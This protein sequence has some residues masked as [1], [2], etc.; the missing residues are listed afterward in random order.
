LQKRETHDRVRRVYAVDDYRISPGV[1]ADVPV[2]ITWPNLR[3]ELG[4]WLT[5]PKPVAEGI[6]TARTLLSGRA[7]H[8]VVRVINLS[9]EPY[10]FHKDD[11]LGEA[12]LATVCTNDESPGS[13]TASMTSPRPA[14][15][16]GRRTASVTVSPGRSPN[17]NVKNTGLRD[18]HIKDPQNAG[19]SQNT[20]LDGSASEP[21]RIW[22]V[23]IGEPEQGNTNQLDDDNCAHVQ[24]LIDGLPRTLTDDQRQEAAEFI[25][26]NAAIF[27]KSEYDLGRTNL[28]EH[29]IDTGDSRPVRQ[30]LRRHPVAYL[31]LIDE[32]VDEMLRNNIIEPKLGSEWISDVV[33]VKK[34]DGSLR[35]CIDYRGLNAVTHKANYP[36][37]RIDSCLDSLGGNTLFS[38]LDMRSSYWQVKVKDEDV[39]KTCFVTRKGIYGFKVLPFGLCNAPST[40]QRLVDLALSGLTWKVCLAYLDDLIVFSRTF[41]EH[42][43]RLQLVFD[44]LEEADL[45]LKP[46]KCS[47]LQERVKFLGSVVTANG[48][49]PDPDKVQAVANWPRPQN[50][51]EVRSF[52]ALASYYRRHIHSFAEIARPLHELTKKNARFEWGLRQEDA[53]LSLKHGLTN[54]PVLAMPMDGGGFVLDTD[55]NQFS[56]R[57]VLQQVQKGVVKVIGYAS[58]AFS[59]AEL[60]YCTT[61]RELA[62]IIYGLKYYRHFLLGFPFVLR[63]D[64]AALTHL[65]RTP[66]PVAQSARYLDILAEYQFTVQYRPGLSHKN[67]DAL[68]RRPCGRG[69]DQPLCK[70]CG[71]I[72]LPSEGEA[73]PP[74]S[75][76][77][78]EDNIFVKDCMDH[79]DTIDEHSA[80]GPR[81]ASPAPSSV[82]GPQ[83][84][85]PIYSDGTRVATTEKLPDGTQLATSDGPAEPQLATSANTLG[86]RV[87]IPNFSTDPDEMPAIETGIAFVTDVVLRDQQGRDTVICVVRRWIETP[88]TVPDDNELHT[89]DPAIQHL[90]AQRQTLEVKDGILYR[91]YMRPDGVLRYLQVVVPRSLRAYFLDAVHTG[92]ING[93]MGVEK[94]QLKLQEIAYWQGWSYDVQMYVRRCHVCGSYRH[95][96]RRK[97]GQL[98]RALAND[99]MQKVHVDLVG[100]FPLSKKG[101]RYLLTAICGFTKY[102]ICVPIRNK[103]S[104]SVAD[105]LMKHVYLIYNPPEIMVHDQGGEF[106]SDV[107]RRLATL[108]DV[109]PSKI[110]SHRPNSNGVIERVHSTLHSMFAKMVDHHQ[111]DWC[112]LSAYVTYAYNTASHSSS[113]FSPFYLMFLRHPRMP[114]ELQVE[115]PTDAAFE[116]DVEYVELASERMRVAYGIVRNHLRATFDRAKKRYDS[117]VKTAKFAEGQF[118]WHYIPRNRKGF[119]KKWELNN[120]GP[121]R[122]MKKLNDVNYIIQKSPR[123]RPTIVHI[124]RLTPYYGNSPAIWKAET[125][126]RAIT[127]VHSDVTVATD[128]TSTAAAQRATVNKRPTEQCA[129]EAADVNTPADTLGQ[130]IESYT[131]RANIKSSDTPVPAAAAHTSERLRRR[132]RETRVRSDILT[133]G[134]EL[135]TNQNAASALAPRRQARAPRWLENYVRCVS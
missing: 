49:E 86:S 52:V 43:D 17:N 96:P 117:R 102:L 109:Q 13:D 25:R 87:A 48:I 59:A 4:D 89:L 128:K 115:K 76:S 127:D 2:S 97:Q 58:K 108:L 133:D 73:D 94:T 9:D 18:P 82:Q 42:L 60:R 130:H 90:W 6:I 62:A 55:A 32:H 30:A 24:C 35:Y 27:S 135:P 98:Q 100:P 8:S 105:A 132:A 64:H 22:S 56:I 104:I 5:E 37:P 3:A 112:E 54:A 121:F 110:S 125:T 51:T 99:V 91:R 84:A 134:A 65:M 107:M 113:S 103:H 78:T 12:S 111:R 46:S 71:P 77:A 74:D 53:F 88:D 41:D 19:P 63:T 72:R 29:K 67:A 118:V 101:F 66:N 68:S 120:R 123:A 114:I 75:G 10:T 38:C 69:P 85:R 15:V 57:C 26:S 14:Q 28:V 1:Q 47:V 44:R 129:S 83:S 93:H 124:D 11:Q 23:R 16:T 33:L 81:P 39:E 92:P 116:T 7:L 31:P 36:L 119:N 34:K 106:W 95:G 50:L 122:I 80:T 61:R 45:K 126:N 40:F 20:G 21:Q 131:H 79:D 70:Q